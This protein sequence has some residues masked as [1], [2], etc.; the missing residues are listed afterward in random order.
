MQLSPI[1]AAACHKTDPLNSINEPV[2]FT[3]CLE[4][5]ESAIIML[6]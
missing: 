6:E 3:E 2:L 5:D 1:I 4:Q